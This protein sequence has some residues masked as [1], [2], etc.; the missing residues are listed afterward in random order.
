[1]GGNNRKIKIVADRDIP[2]LK[3]A[4]EKVARV[5]YL[6]GKVI[7]APAVRQADA[8]IIRTRTRCNGSLLNGSSLRFIATASIGYDHI[9]T[10]YCEHRGI[11]WTN[12]PGCNSSSVEQ[13]MLSVLLNLAA[14]KGFRLG[15]KTIGIVGVGH[16]GGKVERICR[17]LGMKVLLND[18]PR[19]RQEGPGK[20]V[21]LNRIRRE[22]DIISLHV[23]LNQGGPDRTLHL[24]DERFF[25]ALARRP[26]L[27]N[28]SRGEVVDSRALK[29]ALTKGMISGATLD[30][31]E[32]E[33]DPDLELM[34]RIDFATPHIAG[35]SVDGKANAT[36]MSIRA[37]SR[38][39]KLGLEDW[40]PSDLPGP[41]NREIMVDATGMDLQ[42]I[43][44]EVCN[45]AYDVRRDDAAL[46]TDPG[47]FEKL[48]AHYP[49]RREPGAF[50]VKLLNDRAGAGPTLKKLGFRILEKDIEL[51]T[52]PE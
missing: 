50:R 14:L 43:L 47:S 11:S 21:D 5:D 52:K 10:A 41:Q 34:D 48:R 36:R 31:W 35:Y 25:A 42:A 22:A 3:G 46:R 13:Y 23:P 24:A 1:V 7:D 15:D 29:R 33:P 12:A 8:L 45:R 16:V 4:L 2:F 19:E 30:V 20:F 27:V 18:P 26:F 38:F 28:S 40:E 44:L 37:L 49:V 9:D 32:G 51:L 17:T 6:P 39:F